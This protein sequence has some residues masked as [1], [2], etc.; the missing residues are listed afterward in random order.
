MDFVHLLQ[1]AAHV[2]VGVGLRPL[3]LFVECVGDLNES[4]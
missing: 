4:Q 1:I 2:V 3:A